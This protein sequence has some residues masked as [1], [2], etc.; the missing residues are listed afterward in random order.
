MGI[1]DQVLSV[2]DNTKRTAINNVKGLIE[3]P[4]ENGKLSFTRLI[5]DL[6]ARNKKIASGN[7]DLADFLPGGGATKGIS[8][9]FGT[10]GGKLSKTFPI[11]KAA[12]FEKAEAAGMN[13]RKATEITGVW[14]GLD[15][16]LRYEIPDNN[17]KLTKK[18]L[19]DTSAFYDSTFTFSEKAAPKIR[20][21]PQTYSAEHADIIAA[22]PQLQG[23]LDKAKITEDINSSKAGVYRNS[24]TS[25]VKKGAP[26][27]EATANS[28]QTIRETLSHEL[29]HAVQE[30]EGF[31]SGGTPAMFKPENAQAVK[32]LGVSF[33]PVGLVANEGKSEFQ[34]YRRLL[35]EA[36]SRAVEARIDMT[37]EER[38]K[39]LFE[40]SYDVPIS[41]M[42]LRRDAP[43]P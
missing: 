30:I 29:N 36:D 14:R 18:E 38:L 21:S 7:I 32:D 31:P 4:I 39:T 9:M 24:A 20:L 27:I 40:D 19:V 12:M 5:E 35:G 10:V 43:R 15:G 28:I 11:A 34:K 17:L 1:L 23:I 42:I 33:D 16:Q 13:P 25:A 37:P 2:I 6:D 8:G 41:E 26:Q 22:Y 3:D